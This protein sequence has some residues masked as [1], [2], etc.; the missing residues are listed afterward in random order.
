M[1]GVF[2]KR[3]LKQDKT[4]KKTENALA[5]F[6]KEVDTNEKLLFFYDK[7]SSY[8]FS[9]YQAYSIAKKIK[10]DFR[11]LLVPNPKDRLVFDSLFPIYKKELV[12]SLRDRGLL[13]LGLEEDQNI[14]GLLS[15]IYKKYILKGYT[16]ALTIDYSSFFSE[17]D[18]NGLFKKL[19]NQMLNP[20]LLKIL[21]LIINNE[22]ND[23]EQVENKT[24]VKLIGHGIPQ[25]LAFSPLLACFYALE[26]DDEYIQNESVVGFRYIDD[27]LILSKTKEN[28]DNIYEKIKEISKKLK[29]KPHD[30]GTKGK[31][32]IKDLKKESINFLGAEF[33]NDKAVVPD[34][35]FEKF[36]DIIKNE[37][38]NLRII[39]R[40]NAVEI[41]KV[42]F[43]YV[44]GW[45][46]YYSG[47]FENDEL[48]Y[49]KIDS[50]LYD[51]YFKKDKK[52]LLFYNKNDWIK[53]FNNDFT[54]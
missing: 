4:H 23:G 8:E 46:N 12:N 27:I 13:G 10:G 25:G 3:F 32:E 2:L 15:D 21:K 26:V 52:R 53:L 28:L 7:L 42:Y 5:K 22:I 50:I 14:T 34:Y 49:K 51:R 30:L 35:V 19:E 24:G 20:Y 11:P 17:I 40:K 43:E 45:L 37:I 18:R 31:T 9:P 6:L 44:R 48:L 47:I 29:M 38:F 1:D 41:K 36:L 33:K 16:H 39:R 54:K